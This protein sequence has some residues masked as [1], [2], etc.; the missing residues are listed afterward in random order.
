M[1]MCN[2]GEVEDGSGQ[3]IRVQEV[4]TEPYEIL[5]ASL[6][7]RVCKFLERYAITPGDD[8]KS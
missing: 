3:R 6:V 7:E 1:M 8:V 4:L 2:P 5:Q